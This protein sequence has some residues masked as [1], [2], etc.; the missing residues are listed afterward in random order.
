MLGCLCDR[1]STATRLGF[2][3]TIPDNFGAAMKIIPDRAPVHTQERLWRRDFS[4]GAKLRR[5]DLENGASHLDLYH[6]EGLPKGNK[7]SSETQGQIVGARGSLNGRKNM[8]RRKIKN[9]EK[10]PWRQCLTRPVPNG[11][12]R[13]AF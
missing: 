12:R 7:S 3:H 4:N 9:G 6:T 8:A 5:A 1:S 2:G 13:S 10:S 11:C